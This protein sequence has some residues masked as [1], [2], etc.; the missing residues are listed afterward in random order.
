MN[1]GS[2]GVYDAQVLTSKGITDV[3]LSEKAG[4]A[5]AALA[6]ARAFMNR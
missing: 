1:A 5:A 4:N 6:I 2:G 3:V